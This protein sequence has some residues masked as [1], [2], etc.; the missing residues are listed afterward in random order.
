MNNSHDIRMSVVK[1]LGI[2][3]VVMA[4]CSYH[5]P[6]Y[7]FV[8]GYNV[9]FFFF[10]SG[11]FF[12]DKYLNTPFV[13]IKSKI[14]RLYFPWVKYGIT[15]VLLHNL[16]LNLHILH[17]NINTHKYI[18]TYSFSEILSKSFQVLLFF[19]WKEVLLAPLWFLFGLFSGIIVLY[20]IS[21]I[22]YKIFP[23]KIELLRFLAILLVMVTGFTGAIYFPEYNMI[24]R[25]LVIAGLIYTGKLYG[26]YEQK[27]PK[28]IFIAITFFLLYT[29]ST[30]LSNDI[31]VGAMRFDNPFVF[32]ITSIAG[33]YWLL[34][35]SEYLAKS[36]S[37]IVKLL[38]IIGENTLTIMALHYLAFKLVNL[39]QIAIYNYPVKYLAYYPVIPFKTAYWWVVYTIV[40]ILVPL[41]LAIIY[42]K[43]KYFLVSSSKS[44]FRTSKEREIH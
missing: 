44:F 4:H 7:K 3:F 2:I 39:L 31:N 13:F 20:T 29:I 43:T 22:L 37:L 30:Y 40:G 1:A 32:L 10:L 26:L 12:K 6:F 9:V 21:F 8:H 17:Y 33:F 41:L 19:R 24:N 23:K 18:D 27:I 34:Y 14:K 35:L 25:T 28:S 36:D 5:T 16:F 42:D 38:N 11:Y 15:F